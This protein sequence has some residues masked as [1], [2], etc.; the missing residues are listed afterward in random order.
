M[1][2]EQ[3]KLIEEM[4]GRDSYYPSSSSSYS[5]NRPH[6]EINLFDTKICKSFLVGTCPHD[7]FIGTKE[8]FGKCKKTH[9]EKFKIYYQNQKKNYLNNLKNDNNAKDGK[10]EKDKNS[11][12]GDINE[13]EKQKIGDKNGQPQNKI[14]NKERDQK[15]KRNNEKERENYKIKKMIEEFEIEYIRDLEYY[16]NEC[17]FKIVQ[18]SE[19][20]KH[21]PEEELKVSK[22]TKELDN[23]DNKIGII[24]QEIEILNT[25]NQVLKSIVESNKLNEIILQRKKFSKTIRDLIDN[26]GQVGQQKLEVCKT[27]GAYLSRLDSDRRLGDHFIGK[28]HLAYVF[29]RSELEE[30]KLKHGYH[31]N[32]RQKMY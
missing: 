12:N 6:R 19:N 8:V 30:L 31:S 4:M 32:K 7:L 17:N 25:N 10:D 13:K 28:I 11:T 3:R 18:A 26:I 20:L 21:T 1:A 15:I 16:I 2:A 27:C 22:L 14:D 24:I 9:S 29:M 23:M 5:Y